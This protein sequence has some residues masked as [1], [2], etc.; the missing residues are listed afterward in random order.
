MEVSDQIQVSVALLS[1][2][3]SPVPM[4][5]EAGWTLEYVWKIGK[6][7]LPPGIKHDCSVV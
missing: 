2:K 1:R 7:L 5:K 4:K 6:L 3:Y